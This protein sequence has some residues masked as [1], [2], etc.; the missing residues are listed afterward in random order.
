V[1]V[2]DRT[3]KDAEAF[4]L[5]TRQEADP[6][7]RRDLRRSAVA[8]SVEAAL[9]Q[10]SGQTR[11]L[12]TLR[13]ELARAQYDYRESHY[14][15]LGQ[16]LPRLLDH[17]QAAGDSQLLTDVYNL[18]TEF[19][20]KQNLD[21]LTLVTTERSKAAAFATGSRLAVAEAERM[22][23][24]AL[25][26]AGRSHTAHT[27][28]VNAASQLASASGLGTEDELAQY[29]ALFSTAAYTA[30]VAGDGALADDYGQEADHTAA[31]FEADV[32][33]ALWSFGPSQ[34]TLY[35]IGIASIL[36]DVGRALG[37]AKRLHPETLP[38]PE[39]RARYWIDVARA[40]E[41]EDDRNRTRDALRRA[42]EQA[43]QEVTRRPA[44]A[45]LAGRVGFVATA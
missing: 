29:G 35:R 40:Y 11:P 28:A 7:R 2:T 13:S 24:I 4:Y 18:A 25:R 30:A 42:Y 38:T 33:R 43:P 36:G 32:P 6:A 39:R 41:Q 37:F 22:V 31:R 16:R 10:P 1:C 27:L 5:S 19:L 21:D 12:Q 26:H 8:L 15:A 3:A 45:L 34:T 20:I 23:C 44:I 17:A 9:Y 14:A